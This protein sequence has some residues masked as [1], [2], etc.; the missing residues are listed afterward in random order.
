MMTDANG[1]DDDDGGGVCSTLSSHKT[2]D[3]P[4]G[5]LANRKPKNDKSVTTAAAVS[6]VNITTFF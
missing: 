3:L 6:H 2:V 1:Y 5:G 4:R